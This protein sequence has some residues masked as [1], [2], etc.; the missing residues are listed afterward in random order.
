MPERTGLGTRPPHRGC[1]LANSMRNSAFCSRGTASYG[2]ASPVTARKTRGF[3]PPNISCVPI[4]IKTGLIP[5]GQTY[6]EIPSRLVDPRAGTERIP[7]VGKI[8]IIVPAENIIQSQ[9]EGCPFI[10]QSAFEIGN[11]VSRGGL[12]SQ[13]IIN[14]I[15][16]SRE[17]RFNF[18]EKPSG[19]VAQVCS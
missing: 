15:L 10:V 17:Q 7:L 8:F 4:C 18:P 19:V 14:V 12:L 9:P 2:R 6:E 3:C 5:V 1:G 13:G 11:P 16:R